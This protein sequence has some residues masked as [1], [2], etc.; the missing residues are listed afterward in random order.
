MAERRPSKGR[1][2][3][4]AQEDRLDTAHNAAAYGTPSLA[5]AADERRQARERLDRQRDRHALYDEI[6][7][8]YGCRCYRCQP[9]RFRRRWAA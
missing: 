9:W 8:Y 4:P 5:D 1:A 2:G 3:P 7:R 6:A